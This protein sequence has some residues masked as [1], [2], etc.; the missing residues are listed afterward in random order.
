MAIVTVLGAGMMG[1]AL[2]YPISDAG[3]TVRLVGTHLDEAWVDAMKRERVHP[4]LGV[5]LP[6]RVTPF[7]LAELE[8]ALDG[9]DIVAVGVSSAGVRWAAQTLGPLLR[10]STPVIAVTKGLEESSPGVLRILPE[11]FRDAL[12]DRLQHSIAPAAI[13]G[14]C[15]AGELARRIPTAVVFTGRDR[16]TL[17][18]LAAAFSTPYYHVRVS[19]DPVG[20][21]VCAALKNAY[22]MAVGIGAG[23]HERAGLPP[24]P[25]AHHNYESA[26]FA[27]ACIEMTRLV[28]ALGGDSD[29]VANLAGAGDMLVTCSGGR[30]SRLGKLLGSGLTFQQARDRMPGD[31]LESADVVR[32]V[33]GALHAMAARGALQPH[34]MPLMRHL[35]EVIVQGATVDMPFQAFFRDADTPLA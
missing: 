15:I 22:A 35:H 16:P 6:E 2:C 1:T 9:V 31:T 30:S 17:E 8:S 5:P 33:G 21:E 24:G 11:V 18:R 26:I 13:G 29:Q 28:R 3:N 10:A 14:P 19:T 25:V 20:V 27:Q 32:V 34:A 12:P 4:K 7:S 23:V